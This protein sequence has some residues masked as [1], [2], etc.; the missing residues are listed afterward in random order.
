MR[1]TMAE[2]LEP[3]R[4]RM[5]QVVREQ[6]ILRFTAEFEA[7]TNEIQLLF[8]Q[9]QVLNWAQN[10][11]GGRLP[12]EAWEGSAFEYLA[13][14]RTTLATK[15]SANGA[16]IWALRQDDPDKEVARRVWTTEVTIGRINFGTPRLSVRL[17]ASTDEDALIVEPHVPGF[18]NQLA[19]FKLLS[20][21]GVMLNSDPNIIN[22]LSDMDALIDL[23]VSPRR[24]IPIVIATGDERRVNRNSPLIDAKLLSKAM[25]GLALVFVV[26]A[27]FTRAL[28]DT[29]GRIRSVYHG[30]VRIYLPSFDSDSNPYEHRLFLADML[31]ETAGA[32]QC[33]REIRQFLAKESL[34][35]FRLHHDVLTFGAVRSSVLKEAHKVTITSGASEA[36]KLSA[37]QLQI[38][39]LEDELQKA[40]DWEDQLI[41]YNTETEERAT[42]AEGQVRRSTERIRQLQRYN[43][44]RGAKPDEEVLLP[45]SWDDLAEWCDSYLVGRLILSSSARRSMKKPKFEDVSLVARSLIWLATEC[46][47]RRIEGGGS[48]NN[49]VIEKSLWNASCGDDAYQFDFQAKRL[50]ADWHIKN[51]GNTHDPVRCLR[52]YYCWDEHQQQIV[53]A[54]LPAHVKT[55]AS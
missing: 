9:K 23:L 1:T 55:S 37:A 45:E 43:E 16:E 5:P 12:S 52:I 3:I 49:F 24:R 6:E 25:V 40:K 27:D 11:S 35:R 51:G 30:G 39:A 14:G 42:T 2:A 44:Q 32:S 38:Q 50:V 18:V 28:S 13:G 10:R 41:K 46:R 4:A 15:L 20:A 17:L 53:V 54:D 48:V 29:F 34:L 26:P 19:E 33:V 21:F 31:A 7:N 22:S 36:E 8:A 47:D